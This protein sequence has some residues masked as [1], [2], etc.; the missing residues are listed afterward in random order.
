MGGGGC[1]SAKNEER[2]RREKLGE[3]DRPSSESCDLQRQSATLSV[4]LSIWPYIQLHTTMA[5]ARALLR[6]E[7]ASRRIT[8]P[9]ASYTSDGKLLCNLCETL[10]KS[11]AQ[12]QSHLHSTQ[13]NLRSQRQ[14]NVAATRRTGGDGGAKKRK[15]DSIES[16]PQERKKARAEPAPEV[17]PDADGDEAVLEDQAPIQ[18]VALS[19]RPN[20]TTKPQ[21]DPPANNSINEADIAAFEKELD[22]LEADAAKEEREA[23]RNAAT[24]SAAPMTAEELAA[25]AREEQSAQRGR[26]DVELEEER[27]DAARVLEDE[28]EEM[29]GLE[30]RV[31]RL[32]E[33]REGLRGKTDGETGAGVAIVGDASKASVGEEKATDANED[34]GEE[35]E[36]SDDEDEDFDEWKFGGS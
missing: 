25:Q 4:S 9:H 11:E 31:R 19:P 18:T 24:I 5:D 29:E 10:V 35:V 27:E 20:G 3:M 8:H 2:W 13:H 32:R 26:R 6:A 15:A 1:C 12:W 30:E 34:V 36:S 21:P 17:A 14:Q 7:R 22:A 33:R 23:L 16:P 28:L